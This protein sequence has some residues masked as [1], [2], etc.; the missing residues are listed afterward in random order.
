[1]TITTLSKPN[2]EL[3][4]NFSTKLHDYLVKHFYAAPPDGSFHIKRIGKKRWGVFQGSSARVIHEIRGSYPSAK[5]QFAVWKVTRR[6][7][8]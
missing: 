1:M 8:I 3:A 2:A 6:L 7:N 5:E 4:A